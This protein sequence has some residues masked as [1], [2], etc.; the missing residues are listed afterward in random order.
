[1]SFSRQSW[2]TKKKN[3]T[4]STCVVWI[5]AFLFVAIFDVF[6]GPF[7]R[8]AVTLLAGAGLFAFYWARDR[9]YFRESDGSEWATY[10][11]TAWASVFLAGL[12]YFIPLTEIFFCITGAGYQRFAE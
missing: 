9:D 12:S 1:M 6:N 8:V 2:D 10:S 5:A 7:I 3:W 4:T 11:K